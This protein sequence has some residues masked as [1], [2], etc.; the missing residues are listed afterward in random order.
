[1]K[2]CCECV[3][4]P[5][6]KNLI[7]ASGKDIAH[8]RICGAVDTKALGRFP[9]KF[10]KTFRTLIRYYYSEWDYHSALGGEDIRSIFLTENPIIKS[11]EGMDEDSVWI[12]IEELIDPLM[13]DESKNINLLTAHG[14]DIYHYSPLEALKIKA[15]P[16]FVHVSSELRQKN[17]FLLEDQI[18]TLLKP[19]LPKVERIVDAGESFFRARIGYVERARVPEVTSL[20]TCHYKPFEGKDLGAPTPDI[21]KPGRLNRSGV[22]FLYAATNE[23]T[24]IAEVRPHPGQQVSL[25]EFVITRPLKVADFAVINFDSFSINEDSLRDLHTIAAIDRHLSEPI[26]PERHSLYSLPQL[27]ADTIRQE[28]YDAVIF[29]SSVSKG[30]NITAFDP[31][32]MEYSDRSANVFQIKEVTY[33]FTPESNID[34][35][36]H[37]VAKQKYTELDWSPEPF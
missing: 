35:D 22:S 6:L 21:S 20:V 27:L 14:R 2:F 3:V 11:G 24:A 33:E 5:A 15:H 4:H 30:K 13:V 8:C 16:T 25:G 32:S 18:K 26:T 17:Y 29:N 28:G 36:E 9:S 10:R 7:V 31:A 12:N 19:L 23:K 34:E 1:M 37:Y